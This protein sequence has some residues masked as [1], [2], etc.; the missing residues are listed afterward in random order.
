MF[1]RNERITVLP[2][3][4]LYRIEA[5]IEQ[6]KMIAL[7]IVVMLL[8]CVLVFMLLKNPEHLSAI[9]EQGQV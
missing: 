2:Y 9:F 4:V 7:R 8:L 3:S 1:L 6:L 5:E